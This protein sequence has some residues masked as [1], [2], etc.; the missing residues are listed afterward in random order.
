MAKLMIPTPLRKYTNNEAYFETESFTIEQAIEEL[1]SEH[2]DLSKH[3]LDNEGKL[4]SYIKV[5]VGD[6]DIR[7]LK[8]MDTE[9]D[10]K[11]IVSIVPAIA[12]GIDE[13]YKSIVKWH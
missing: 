4:R 3:L 9:I 1:V 6:D 8:G 12:G 11:D 5:F 13:F 2:A 10:E 7:S